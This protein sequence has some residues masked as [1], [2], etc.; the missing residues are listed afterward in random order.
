MLVEMD[1]LSQEE[2]GFDEKMREELSL[3]QEK[4]DAG[5][6]ESSFPWVRYHHLKRAEHEYAQRFRVAKRPYRGDAPI[7]SSYAQIREQVE[8]MA[9]PTVE[10][11]TVAPL[12]SSHAPLEESAPTTASKKQVVAP[13]LESLCKGIDDEQ[14]HEYAAKID[15]MWLNIKN[16]S[17]QSNYRT[18]CVAVYKLAEWL[19]MVHK[20]VKSSE[21]TATLLA[22]FGISIS[23][24][25]SKYQIAKPQKSSAFQR[26]V[27]ISFAFA[28]RN[29][30]VLAKKNPLPPIY[31]D[32]LADT[33]KY[34]K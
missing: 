26:A 30:A 15:A 8:D 18:A 28:E 2:A 7:E 20:G 21:W 11:S 31:R 27:M 6:T 14:R 5:T 4:I 22:R 23:E 13:T 9:P 33:S 16:Q 17:L 25:L 24:A 10:P 19:G 34:R 12:A 1:P 29:V 3:L 32:I